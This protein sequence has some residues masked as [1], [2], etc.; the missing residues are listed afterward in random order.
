MSPCQTNR[1]TTK[2]IKAKAKPETKKQ[3]KIRQ[4][5]RFL[6]KPAT[7]HLPKSPFDIYLSRLP[8]PKATNDPCGD[9]V[10]NDDRPHPVNTSRQHM[11]RPSDRGRVRGFFV[12]GFSKS[13]LMGCIFGCLAGGGACLVTHFSKYR[14]VFCK[15]FG[16]GVFHYLC[17]H[18]FSFPNSQNCRPASRILQCA[19]APKA[20]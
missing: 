1:E 13:C 7:L 15:M 12:L 16:S 4:T 20:G 18:M 3:T 9:Q 14:C 19:A 17:L 5:Y 2:Q 11:A 10:P 8:I 6:F